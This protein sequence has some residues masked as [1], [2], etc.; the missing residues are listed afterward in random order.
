MAK[1]YNKEKN[2]KIKI[3]IGICFISIS[4][5]IIALYI[6]KYYNIKKTIDYN[7]EVE[8]VS[9][10]IADENP[11]II[12]ENVENEQYENEEKQ[13]EITKIG[14]YKVIGKIIIEKIDLEDVILEKTTD[15]SLN[16]GLT[17]FWG[18]GINKPGNVSIT[19]HNYKIERSKLFSELD[20]L[21]KGDTF[22]LE[23]MNKNRIIYKIYNKYTVDPEDT[24]C[25]DQNNDGKREVTLITCTKGAQ[26]RIIIKARE[27]KKNCQKLL[28]KFFL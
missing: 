20:K 23:D 22:E 4:I 16:L 17:K 1:R 26:K 25:I 19:G 13:E 27:N 18:P 8:I 21:Q 6:W 12:E 10:N 15:T 24:S 5:C 11:T 9:E 14:Q 28:D 2:K 7:T 3:L